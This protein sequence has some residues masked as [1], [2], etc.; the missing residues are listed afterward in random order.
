M[1]ELCLVR[2]VTRKVPSNAIFANLSQ[3]TSMNEQMRS[4]IDACYA[5]ALA[6]DECAV[7]CLKEEDFPHLARCIQLDM[8]C[9]DMCRLAM[10]YMGRD[11]ELVNLIC[12]TCAE[13][14]DACAEECAHHDTMEHCRACEEACRR[15]ADECRKLFASPREAAGRNERISSH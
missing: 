11:S 10:A 1:L 14:C 2:M 8:D 15:C 7:S 4:C 12:Q 5:C 3:E 13:I 6:C 9:A